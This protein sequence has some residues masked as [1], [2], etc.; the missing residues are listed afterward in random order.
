REKRAV[1][2]A[3]VHGLQAGGKARSRH[4]RSVTPGRQKIDSTENSL[5]DRI[6]PSVGSKGDSYDNALAETIIGLFKSGG[7]I[8][9]AS[10]SR[11]AIFRWSSM[12]RHT[13]VRGRTG[14]YSRHSSNQTSDKL[15]A[16]HVF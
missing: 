16:V 3:Q 6:E 10:W 11:S 2:R 5:L 8:T 9:T 7:S 12:R 4:A 14:H 1:A 15:E 13:S